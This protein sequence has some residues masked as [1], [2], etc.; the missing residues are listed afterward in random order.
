MRRR[1][2]LLLTYHFPPSAAVAV[3]RALGIAR[4]LPTYD[5]DVI[6]V[7]ASNLPNEP[8]DPALI[9]Q[10]PTSTIVYRIP[11]PSQRLF[12]YLSHYSSYE[13][14][15]RQAR[16]TVL[17]V[18][19]K[20]QPDVLMT[21]SP[22]GSIHTLGAWTKSNTGLPWIACLRDPWSTTAVE[23]KGRLNAVAAA[24][25][26]AR[27]MRRADLIVANTPRLLNAL[28]QRYPR[29]AA[30]MTY[31]TN[32][33][34]LAGQQQLKESLRPRLSAKIHPPPFVEILHAG[35]IYGK[36]DASALFLALQRLRSKSD[37][38]FPEI[39]LRLVG[40]RD[41]SGRLTHML[42]QLGIQSIVDLQDQLPYAETMLSM[43]NAD[44]LLVLQSPAYESAIPAK[45]FEYLGAEKPVLA[46]A[47]GGD[48]EWALRTAGG[49]YRIASPTDPGAIEKA[50][51]D[52]TRIVVM[53]TASPPTAE[54]LRVFT[55]EY[56]A[57]RLAQLLN[58]LLG[59]RAA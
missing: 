21:T 31:L 39:R 54:G 7:A 55:R 48:V 53:Q 26:E 57:E 8:I 34:D 24:L 3:Y 4:H 13:Y 1:K 58:Q 9:D 18:I 59:V 50:I 5:W 49:T 22:P 51:V 28:K 38:L 16:P 36:R 33:F 25:G 45:L 29:K 56:I 14:W 41:S 30:K 32:G 40:R 52:L 37:E 46:L 12:R 44:I 17:N 42:K 2:L 23:L 19:H 35:E 27:T 15:S 10:I 6:I 11:Y 43:L 20:Y 47:D